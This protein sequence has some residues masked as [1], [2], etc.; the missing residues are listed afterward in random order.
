MLIILSVWYQSECKSSG[1][2]SLPRGI[3]SRTSDLE[4]QSLGGS[5]RSLK[6]KVCEK[7]IPLAMAE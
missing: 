4:M 3:V 5:P 1:G 6:K 7:F 2:E